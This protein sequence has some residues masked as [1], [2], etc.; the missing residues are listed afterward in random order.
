MTLNRLVLL[1][2]YESVQSHDDTNNVA[3]FSQSEFFS[4]IIVFIAKLRISK[5]KKLIVLIFQYL[6]FVLSLCQSPCIRLTKSFSFS[7]VM[8]F[9]FRKT[10]SCGM[11]LLLKMLCE[12]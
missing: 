6:K 8:V 4:V 3:G 9:R 12:I 2:L 5:L 10:F 11:S 7:D 1:R